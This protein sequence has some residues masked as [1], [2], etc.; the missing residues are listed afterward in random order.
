VAVEKERAHEE[1]VE[2][3]FSS[4]LA[5]SNFQAVKSF[6]DSLAAELESK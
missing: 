6:P 3:R 1:G 2:K 5:A 4:P